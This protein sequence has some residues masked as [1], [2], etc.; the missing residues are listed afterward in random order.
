MVSFVPLRR[1]SFRA[2]IFLK[3][4][5][6]LGWRW[7]GSIFLFCWGCVFIKLVILKVFYMRLH[8]G[9][10]SFGSVFLRGFLQLGL[11]LRISTKKMAHL[12]IDLAPEG[13]V[14]II[15]G[16]TPNGLA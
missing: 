15:Q 16:L 11:L 8:P 13:C 12:S 14:F 3:R 9:F 4:H 10:P 2:F 5:V 1:A 7:S 6:H